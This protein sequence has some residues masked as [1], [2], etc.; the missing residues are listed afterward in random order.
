MTKRCVVTMAAA[1]VGASVV[2]SAGITAQQPARLLNSVTVVRVKPE[3]VDAWL[4]FQAKRTIPAIK[5]AG[6]TQRDVYE[7]IYGTLGEY[8]IVT[9]LANFANRDN[10]QGPIVRALGEA[11]AKE[12][13]DTLRKMLVS[14]TTTIIEG[15]AD[16]SYDPNPNTI[17]PVLVLTTSHVAPGRV[18]DYLAFLRGER[19]AAVK[20]GES[21]RDLVSRVLFGG[22]NNEFRLASFQDKIAA[23][24]GPSAVQRAL[25]PEGTAKLTAKLAGILTRSERTV[26]RRV[27]ALSFRSRPAS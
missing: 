13:N 26:W 8:R 23:L 3:A 15:I 6:T 5:K 18:A 22:D 1:V 27:E 25:G 4:D 9:P 10:P 19:L 12:Y 24:D 20:K 11:A 2:S 14:S 7:T 21:P 17:H 16:A